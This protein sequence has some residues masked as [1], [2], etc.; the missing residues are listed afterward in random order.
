MVVLKVSWCGIIK[1]AGWTLAKLEETGL[2]AA[3]KA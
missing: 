1:Y 3:A 2:L